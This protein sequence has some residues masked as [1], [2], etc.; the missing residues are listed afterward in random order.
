MP[1]W[2][3]IDACYTVLPKSDIKTCTWSQQLFFD[4]AKM[5]HNILLKMKRCGATEFHTVQT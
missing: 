3:T 1:V 5:C 2:Q 4:K